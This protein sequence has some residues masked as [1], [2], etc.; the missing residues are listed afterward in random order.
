MASVSYAPTLSETSTSIPRFVEGNWQPLFSTNCTGTVPVTLAVAGTTSAVPLVIDGQTVNTPATFNW[1]PGSTHTL[2]AP[3]AT[4]GATRYAFQS[5]SQGGGQS[6]I[7]MAPSSAVTYTANYGTQ[8]YLATTVAGNGT[9]SPGSGWYN[10]GDTAT[11]TPIASAGAY[12]YKAFITSDATKAP[13]TSSPFQVPMTSAQTVTAYF[14]HAGLSVST[15]YVGPQ[16]GANAVM[17]NAAPGW[18]AASNVPW[19]HVSGTASPFS[20]AQFFT[21]TFDANPG[22]TRIGA[23]SFSGIPSSLTVTQAGA[24]YTAATTPISL[25]TSGLSSP[26]GIATDG[27]GTVYFSDTGNN[28]IKYFGPP[29]QSTTSLLASGYFPP[30]S[31]LAAGYLNVG[32]TLLMAQPNGT[33]P[34]VQMYRVQWP[35][36]SFAGNWSSPSP[37]GVAL[38]AI[39][40]AF[41]DDASTDTLY[42]NGVALASGLNNPHGL[43]TD[44]YGNVYIADTGS[45]SI[46]FLGVTSSN[47]TTLVS[48]GLNQPAAVT[49]DGAG[50]VYI[51]DASN[52]VKK[53][54]MATSQLTTIASGFNSPAGLSA[55]PAGNVYIA[56]TG[57]NA[58]KVIP[59]AFIH[60]GPLAESAAAG[61][62]SL[63]DIVPATS[64]TGA[65]APTSD[66]PWLTISATSS[67]P[68]RFSFAANT[69]P[70]AR[71]AHITVMGVTVTVAQAG[72][73]T[74][75]ASITPAGGSNQSATVLTAFSNSL[76]ALVKD[77]AGNPLSGVTVT[78]TAPAIGAGATLSSSSAVT[79]D[80]GIAT[81]T[82]TA[83]SVAGIYNVTAAA[84]GFSTTFALT[85]TAGA[86]AVIAIAGG[87]G[88]RAIVNTA[89]AN[90][91]SVTV[92][93]GAGNL[94]SGASVTFIAP[95]SGA[96]AQFSSTTATT[97]SS[98]IA[99]VTAA[100]NTIAGSYSVTGAV[101]GLS[102]YFALTNTPG[103][104]ATIAVNAGSGQSTLIGTAF[105]TPLSAIVSDQYGN[106]TSGGLVTF[107]APSSGP[108]ATLSSS[109]ATSNAT[110]L[111]SVNASANTTAGSYTVTAML[112]GVPTPAA[113]SLINS[114]P[115]AKL[116]FSTVPASGTVGL[117]QSSTVKILDSAGNLTASTAS[118][119][120]VSTPA[121][122][123][124]TAAAVNGIA[125][126]SNLIFPSA[127]SYTLAAS[128]PGLT[129]ATSGAIVISGL[130]AVSIEAPAANSTL[131]GTVTLSGWALDNATGIGSAISSVQIIV[132][133]VVV[134][135][136]T[137]GAP[138]ADV[139]AA[140]PGRPGCPNVGFSY[141]L[142]SV[143]LSNGLHTLT[144]AATNSDATPHTGSASISIAVSNPQLQ[145]LPPLVVIDP[146]AAA[147]PPSMQIFTG[148]AV[149]RAAAKI[150]A[151]QVAIDGNIAGNAT[152]GL[153]RPDACT[154]TP[155]PFGC[156]NIGFSYSLD[157]ST[158][159]SGQHK[160][161]VTATDQWGNGSSSS[162][163]FGSGSAPSGF[164]V[165]ID[166]PHASAAVS[167]VVTVTG[168]AV[169]LAR[170]GV[171]SVQ[172]KVDGT[173]VGAATYGL[174]RP[175]V[176]ANYPSAAGCPDVGF[177]Y[178]LNTAALAGGSHVLM[179]TATDASGKTTSASETITTPTAPPTVY[180]ESPS[181]GAFVTG[182]ITVSGWA[183]DA[184]VPDA[185]A[186]SSV[187][188]L[189]DGSAAGTATYGSKRTDI[190][191]SGDPRPDCPNIGFTYMLDTAKLTAGPH[192]VTAV[193]SDSNPSPNS[194]SWTTLV[195]VKR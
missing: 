164:T 53:W 32:L 122:V 72:T 55:D 37:Q 123:N 70:T 19:L 59:V 129:G 99:T 151:V 24:G 180:I 100:A 7:I 126:F 36:L 5:W 195:Y 142:N 42:G 104:P 78:F 4:Y 141:Q 150:A 81:A 39:G 146:V 1:I 9:L 80:L 185:S 163:T 40:E 133:G 44:S 91:L 50:N 16:S 66:Q 120:L 31:G 149:G 54:S 169:N 23:I 181:P 119:T 113:F 170:Y 121:G 98:G 13:L 74:T 63:P 161:T 194:A 8:Y 175:D 89:F 153:L 157:P 71:V 56:D 117:P 174:P 68:A 165:S 171:Q 166:A 162:A 118:V 184:G 111:V 47:P 30:P 177:S 58:I 57:N 49:V 6:Q 186:I 192:F 136:A 172:V 179:V 10:A 114:A 138:R 156:P 25:L 178:Q 29:A 28:V 105:P 88:Q 62:D 96:A 64:L 26:T 33:Y 14:N 61:Y 103:A 38:S 148:Y 102:A 90:P 193:A 167:G 131:A 92:K 159:S 21:Y 82:V 182:I 75:P 97:N 110:G 2:D 158:L 190:C 140:Y 85:N 41:Y 22:A 86:P 137:Y 94:V 134:G 79:N 124:V 77:A 34:A 95:S 87:S 155:Q 76:S 191:A 160:V 189:V 43:A 12:F 69:A 152:Y 187:Q 144:V 51:A 173:V 60:P 115:P 127:G 128:S 93:D 107:A 125:S 176:C 15:Q 154:G 45:N 101:N 106:P 35:Y 135:A 112:S 143:T 17:A 168:W 46:K 84:N 52:T 73:S 147:T 145:A 108:S 18:P 67:Y 109:T 83:N 20:T 116:A 132:D 183:I 139:C 3:I 188:I 130:P 27:A 48:A 11:V 65:F